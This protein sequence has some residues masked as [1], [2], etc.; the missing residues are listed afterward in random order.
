[1]SVLSDKDKAAL[2]SE[3]MDPK[4]VTLTCG[5]HHF[6]YGGKLKP[7]FK[8]KRCLFTLFMGL[9]ANTP[10]DKRQEQLEMLEFTVHELIEAKQSGK[11]QDFFKHPEVYV[12][13]KRIGVPKVN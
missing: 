8:C 13:D 10:P 12:N 9:I 2:I 11:L 7:N 1:M 6:A 5:I 3:A 4:K